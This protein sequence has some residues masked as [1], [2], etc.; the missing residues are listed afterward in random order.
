VKV[1]P[2]FDG[3]FI[4]HVVGT[5]AAIL[6]WAFMGGFI[7]NSWNSGFAISLVCEGF[8]GTS[9]TLLVSEIPQL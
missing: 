1:V 3:E 5:T 7:G 9:Y 6:W 2:F 8:I 4:F